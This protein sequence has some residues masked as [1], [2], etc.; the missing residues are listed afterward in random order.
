M[1]KKNPVNCIKY[2]FL[3][4]IKINRAL[5]NHLDCFNCKDVLLMRLFKVWLLSLIGIFIL[6]SPVLAETA[7]HI[8]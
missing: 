4:K 1:F 5:I 7:F 2:F 6:I 8:K 3:P